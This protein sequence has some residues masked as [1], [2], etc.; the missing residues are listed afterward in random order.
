MKVHSKFIIIGRKQ[1][2]ICIKKGKSAKSVLQF[3]AL[4]RLD[5]LTAILGSS[6]I[7]FISTYIFGTFQQQ[8]CGG[9]RNG[10]HGNQISHKLGLGTKYFHSKFHSFIIESVDSINRDE[11]GFPLT[12]YITNWVS[13]ARNI[14]THFKYYHRVLRLI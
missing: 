12:Q 1:E 11:R 3:P 14:I 8:L 10:Y 7:V 9:V 13:R 5:T 6:C 4:C 2:N